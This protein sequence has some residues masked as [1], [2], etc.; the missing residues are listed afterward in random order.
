VERKGARREMG[1]EGSA[2]QK[3]EPMDKNRMEA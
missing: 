2:E 1:S 3:H